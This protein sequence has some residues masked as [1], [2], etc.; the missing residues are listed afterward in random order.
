MTIYSY[1]AY[2]VCSNLILIMASAKAKKLNIK[3]SI[4]K[5]LRVPSD[6][7]GDM[8]ASRYGI[9]TKAS[10][11]TGSAPG[12]RATLE[13]IGRRYGITRE[14]V[15]QIEE[16][17]YLKIRNSD[18]FELLEPAIAQVANF[19]QEQGGVV[20]E[21][22][23]VEALVGDAQRPHLALLLSLSSQ[24]VKIKEG[25]EH[26]N[27][28]A[29]DG[30]HARSAQTLLTNV[31]R[32]LG[33]QEK[34]LSDKELL[35]L[36]S[37]VNDTDLFLTDDSARTILSISKVVQKGPFGKWG[38][39]SWSQV[40]P[41]GV[42]D[43]AYLVFD[44]EERPLHFREIA[45]LIDKA[46]FVTKS[47]KKTHPQTVHNELIKDSRFVLVGRGIYALDKWGYTPGTVRDVIIDILKREAQPLTKE[48]IV[49]KVLEQR[50]V[51]NNTIF[52]NLQNRAHFKKLE[53]RYSLA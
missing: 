41:R 33:K 47:P 44:R 4:E 5:M 39:A 17:S 19:I 16:A 50:M 7:N 35:T 42:R 21:D 20:E 26:K 40:N 3:P 28:W 34:P 2:I 51:Q 25:D 27:S 32:E 11:G 53:G 48:E 1:H 30:E 14:R 45:Q 36:V 9:P 46:P 18:Q 37:A 15:R 52:L 22:A 13:S 8:L 23:L 10:R 12:V 31:I 6:R 24:F 43:K 49:S 38:L 29:I